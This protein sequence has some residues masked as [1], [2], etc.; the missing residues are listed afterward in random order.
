MPAWYFS[1]RQYFMQNAGQDSMKSLC[2]I[3]YGM[4]KYVIQKIVCDFVYLLVH[5]LYHYMN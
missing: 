4:N 2:G 3:F 5:S 1:G